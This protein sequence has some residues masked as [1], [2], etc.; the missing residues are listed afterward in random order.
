MS[1][2]ATISV[3]PASATPTAQ[4]QAL[5]QPSAAPPATAPTDA[6]AAPPEATKPAEG[7]QPE[8]KELASSRFAALAKKEARLQAER[9]H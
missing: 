2:A 6:Q 9:K 7:T 5:T 3:T 4:P 1:E 8:K